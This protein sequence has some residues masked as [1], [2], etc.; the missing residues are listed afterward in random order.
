MNSRKNSRFRA[1]VA[2]TVS[3]RNTNERVGVRTDLQTLSEDMHKTH[4]N[5]SV[6]FSG[7]N[8]NAILEK[9]NCLRMPSCIGFM[10]MQ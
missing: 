10:P 8:D 1:I 5:V 4:N 6:V 9:H 7:G 2:V 3:T